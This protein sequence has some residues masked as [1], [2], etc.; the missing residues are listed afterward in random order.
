MEIGKRGPIQGR[1]SV[2]A[3]KESLQK[4]LALRK[5]RRPSNYKS[6][7]PS[8]FITLAVHVICYYFLHQGVFIF[9]LYCVLNDE[10]RRK[11]LRQS[12]VKSYR[13]LC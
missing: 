1:S 7:T 12:N 5:F 9:V 10:V 4:F 13:K 3:C 11:M 6:K 8:V 2:Y